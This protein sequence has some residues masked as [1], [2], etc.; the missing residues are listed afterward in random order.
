MATEVRIHEIFPKTSLET[1][2]EANDFIPLEVI[3]PGEILAEEL[4]S[5]GI[6]QKDFAREL[7]MTTGHLRCLLK[8]KIDFTER[9]SMLLEQ[10][11]GIPSTDW[12]NMQA[13]YDKYSEYSEE[14]MMVISSKSLYSHYDGMSIEE[15]VHYELVKW[16]YEESDLTEDQMERFKE[17]MKERIEG[18]FILDGVLTELSPYTPERIGRMIKERF[19]IEEQ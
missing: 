17:E 11:L 7:G 8:G 12:M 19:N 5:R 14:E 3:H 18:A 16:G 4:K 10:K 15:V 9:F 1:M 13:H 6:K 2:I